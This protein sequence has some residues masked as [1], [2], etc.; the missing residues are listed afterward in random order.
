MYDRQHEPAAERHL[1][2]PPRVA[3]LGEY[4]SLPEALPEALPAAGP[5]WQRFEELLDAT[6]LTG[7]VTATRRAIAV[8]SGA[9]V[10]D[11]PERV[12]ASSLQL[13]M[14]ARLVSPLIGSILTT[15][16]APLLT[17]GSLRWGSA[18][19]SVRFAATGL[20]WR[21]TEDAPGAAWTIRDTFLVGPM[22]AIVD[23]LH[24]AVSLSPTVMWGNTI[25][26]AHGAVTV[27]GMT[28]PTLIPAGRQLVRV[29]ADTGPLAGTAAVGEDTFTRRSCCLFY[30]AP[31]GG[32]CGDCVLHASDRSHRSH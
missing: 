14:A 21:R 4:F 17:P 31:G 24:S 28:D 2:V 12:A 20:R 11:V 29:L 22:A 19:H 18:G 6:T 26:A 9:E 32:L 16:N 5:D 1:A 10:D 3:R 15:R 23:G 13:A 30:L 27:A 8:S 7:L 25:S